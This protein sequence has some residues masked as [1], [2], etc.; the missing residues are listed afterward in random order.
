MEKARTHTCVAI[1]NQERRF[2][3]R[4]PT[5]KF[6]C[7][8]ELRTHEVKIGLEQQPTCECTCNKPKFLHLPCSHVLALFYFYLSSV[9]LF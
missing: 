7:G 4:L 2:E 1:E 6:G 8:N 5:D 9:L 3:V